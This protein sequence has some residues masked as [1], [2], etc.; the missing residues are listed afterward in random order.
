M[1]ATYGI[2]N[3]CGIAL[4]NST[5]WAVNLVGRSGGAL[6]QGRN[7]GKLQPTNL[8]QP[9]CHQL[10]GSL[11]GNDGPGNFLAD[12]LPAFPSCCWAR[13]N[14]K[15]QLEDKLKERP[16]HE[17]GTPEVTP[18]ARANGLTCAIIEFQK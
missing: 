1:H 3:D 5:L 11:K 2:F 8:N 14:E 17:V 7:F 15:E 12:A 16:Q 6:A 18:A 4:H 9:S 10:P 13:Q